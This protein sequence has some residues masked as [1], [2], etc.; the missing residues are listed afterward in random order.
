M[1]AKQDKRK[2]ESAHE[3][4]GKLDTSVWV[5]AFSSNSEWSNKDEFLDVI[6]WIR[7]VLGLIIGITW[8]VVA[9][10]GFAGIISFSLLNAGLVYIYFN[11]FQK[12]EEE[13]YGGAWEITKEGFMTSFA[14]F[15]VSWIIVYSAIQYG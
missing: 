11:N 15:M 7:Q 5:R 13:E 2:T 4:S 9:M 1:Y 10:K 14:S 6:Y 12:V 8:G 3:I